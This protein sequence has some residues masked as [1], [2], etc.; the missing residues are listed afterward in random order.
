MKISHCTTEKRLR[1]TLTSN[2]MPE[3]QRINTIKMFFIW[4]LHSRARL[5][6]DTARKCGLI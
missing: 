4:N 3:I 6:D 1:K 5:V 2:E